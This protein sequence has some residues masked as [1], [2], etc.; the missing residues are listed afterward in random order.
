MRSPVGSAARR[1]EKP[2][3]TNLEA[4]RMALGCSL[5]D[6]SVFEQA[7]LLAEGDFFSQPNR[8]TYGAMLAIYSRGEAIDPLDVLTVP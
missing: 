7:M 8:L 3:P 1:I 5:L 4:E 2:L 6:N